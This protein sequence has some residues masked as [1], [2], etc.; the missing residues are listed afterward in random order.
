MCACVRLFVCA[1][2][3]ASA[4]TRACVHVCVFSSGP[5][6]RCSLPGNSNC[7]SLNPI[8]TDKVLSIFNPDL[9]IITYLQAKPKVD[10]KVFY[11]DLTD[12]EVEKAAIKIQAGIR[13]YQARK[14]LHG[15]VCLG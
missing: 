4:C 5:F 9:H 3:C 10:I 2:V 1:C 8:S 14:S 6:E 15:K 11:I 7:F 12:P 13:G